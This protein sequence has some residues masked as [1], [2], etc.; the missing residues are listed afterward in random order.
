[1]W[2]WPKIT[3][4]IQLKAPE[5]FMLFT[6][7]IQQIRLLQITVALLAVAQFNKFKI[8]ISKTEFL[9]NA[10]SYC[11]SYKVSGY[12]LTV[13]LAEVSKLVSLQE[14]KGIENTKCNGSLARSSV[15]LLFWKCVQTWETAHLL[16]RW[17]TTK[18]NWLQSLSHA[19]IVNELGLWFTQNQI[20]DN[21]GSYVVLE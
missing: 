2:A 6:L 1:M 20:H 12:S 16:T 19:R 8:L 9:Y 5:H 4:Q 17:K 3:S 11:Y 7:C 21:I 13:S 10:I 18:V 15:K 14:S